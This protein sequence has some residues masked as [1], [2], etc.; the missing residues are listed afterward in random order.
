MHTQCEGSEGGRKKEKTSKNGSRPPND[1]RVLAACVRVS[2]NTAQL[3][4][5]DDD[6]A[7]ETTV[8]EECVVMRCGVVDGVN[9]C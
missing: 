4:D 7:S 9:V 2:I 3:R 6:D 1:E 8:V 5:L